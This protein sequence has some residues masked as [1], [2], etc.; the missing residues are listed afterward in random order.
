MHVGAIFSCFSLFPLVS[1]C[2][3]LS[4]P[5]LLFNLRKPRQHLTLQCICT[6]THAV[7][8][9]KY[10]PQA[11]RIAVGLYYA[12]QCSTSSVCGVVMLYAY[13]VALLCGAQRTV[14]DVLTD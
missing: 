3:Y 11:I 4:V 8:S 12:A 7:R 5:W 6:Y 2:T 13:Y 14:I 10:T 1:T 9:Y